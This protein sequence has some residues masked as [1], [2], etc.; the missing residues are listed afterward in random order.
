[1]I[2]THQHLEPW[3]GGHTA[4]IEA[5]GRSLRKKLTRDAE[6][7]YIQAA[8]FPRIATRMGQIE[9]TETGL[10]TL[11]MFLDKI[12]P[13]PKDKPLWDDLSPLVVKVRLSPV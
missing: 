12:L 11:R 10:F 5:A 9:I 13:P 2:T 8:Y 6:V 3:S 1:V 7:A 4:R